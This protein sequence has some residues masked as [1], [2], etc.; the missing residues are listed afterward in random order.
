MTSELLLLLSKIGPMLLLPE[1]LIVLTL[2]GATI[3]LGLR[4]HRSAAA[5]VM[6][7]LAV[8]WL[9]AMP[10]F[11][12][13]VMGTLERQY[14]ADPAALPRA[15]IAIVLG[16]AVGA[17]VPP[18][19][20]PELYDATDR[21]WY[22]AHLFRSGHVK[23]IIAVGG[24]LPWD[25]LP[26]PEGDVMRDMLITLGVPATAIE[27]GSTSRNTYENATEARTIMRGPPFE[28]ALLVTSAAHMPRALAVFRA[29]G[30]P[31]DPA[32]CDFRSNSRRVAHILDWLPQAGAFA[33]TSSAVRE[34]IG[35]YAY[36]WRGWL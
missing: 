4:A 32:P 34:W 7:A 21:I 11:A 5:L 18:R 14:T 15:E 19:E 17:P 31:V 30:I 12:N 23:R 3:S 6:A 10:V 35:Y 13:W 25:E 28:P 1:G 26:R 9:S 8:F 29:A 33:M 16:G 20:T 24:L 2:L 22:A 36:K 27:I